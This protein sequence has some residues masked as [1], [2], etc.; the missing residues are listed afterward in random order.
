MRILLDECFPKKLK[1]EF[2]GH[3]V[4]M[5]QEMGWRGKDNGALLS[6]AAQEFE[7]FV[8]V[9][10]NIPYQQDLNQFEIGVIILRAD[11]NRMEHLAPLMPKV[12]IALDTVRSG[13]CVQIGG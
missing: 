11:S 7:V 2:A 12:R 3:D 6:A 1:R 9:D 10:Q 8:T 5:V 4:R 13:S